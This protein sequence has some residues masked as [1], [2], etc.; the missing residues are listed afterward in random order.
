MQIVILG[1]VQGA[2]E[3][4]PLSGAGFSAVARSLLGISLEDGPGLYGAL[5]QLAVVAPICMVF[6]RDFRNMRQS[7]RPRRGR[8]PEEVRLAR[9]YPGAAGAGHHPP[10]CCRWR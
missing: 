3:V 10:C 2:A 9:A 8:L 4:L 1:L 6:H 5:I 7:T